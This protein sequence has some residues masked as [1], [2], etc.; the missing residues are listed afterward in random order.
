MIKVI[1]PTIEFLE[2]FFQKNKSDK[3]HQRTN[4]LANQF[5]VLVIS[6]VYK[7]SILPINYVYRFESRI[8]N[9]PVNVTFEILCYLSIDTSFFN[10]KGF[11]PKQVKIIPNFDVSMFKLQHKKAQSDPNAT[12]TDKLGFEVSV[13]DAVVYVDRTA[14]SLDCLHFGVVVEIK[15]TGG[16]YIKDSLNSNKR[17]IRIPQNNMIK[18]T[19]E[20]K[21][22]LIAKK[23][24]DF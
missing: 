14:R 1:E 9:Q 13:G 10:T 2:E 21:K 6:G 15:K 8:N 23:L 4:Q 19:E 3:F 24:A 18:I 12:F 22:H 11:A 17:T 7:G 5:G 16:I 20:Q